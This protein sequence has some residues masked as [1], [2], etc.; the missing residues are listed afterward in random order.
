MN[1]EVVDVAALGIARPGRG[2]GD[3]RDNDSGEQQG[4]ISKVAVGI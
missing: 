2:G 1:G 4:S 3:D